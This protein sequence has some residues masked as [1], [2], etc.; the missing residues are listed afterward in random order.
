M[1]SADPPE[2]WMKNYKAKTCKKAVS[3]WGG[4]TALC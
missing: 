3:E 1:G 4:R 2:K